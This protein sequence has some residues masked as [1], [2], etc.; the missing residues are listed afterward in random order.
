MIYGGDCGSEYISGSIMY[1]TNTVSVLLPLVLLQCSW[2][3]TWYRCLEEEVGSG[4]SCLIESCVRVQTQPLAL[5]TL[6]AF[7]LY[8]HHRYSDS[9]YLH[10]NFVPQT[11]SSQITPVAAGRVPF[12]D[13]LLSMRILYRSGYGDSTKSYR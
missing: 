6:G 11:Q 8:T 5:S 1:L 4:R 3:D 13:L 10:V 7:Y 12:N 2:L 9:R